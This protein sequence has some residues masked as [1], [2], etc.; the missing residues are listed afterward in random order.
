MND[1]EWVRR[2]GTLYEQLM[3]E[4]KDDDYVI[5]PPQAEK[6]KNLVEFL[7]K[8][9]ELQHGSM[10]KIELVPKEKRGD[11]LV[12]FTDFTIRGSKVRQ[13]CELLSECSVFGVDSLIDGKVCISC[14]I[15]NVFVHK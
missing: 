6:F 9:V 3:S 5:N 10:D 1:E 13:A 14:T 11:V 2:L 15:P 7:A 8:E 12:Y 4:E